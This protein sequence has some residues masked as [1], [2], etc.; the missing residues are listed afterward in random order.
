V[1][2]RIVKTDILT[3]DFMTVRL[4]SYFSVV[5]EQNVLNVGADS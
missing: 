5:S 2:L 1:E 4:Y 3:A